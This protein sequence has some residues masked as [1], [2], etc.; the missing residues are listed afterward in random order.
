MYLSVNGDR[1][2]HTEREGFEIFDEKGADEQR[3]LL[4]GAEKCTS[5]S[6]VSPALNFSKRRQNVF[7]KI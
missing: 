6:G 4:T 7:C 3:S 5:A 1:H 2:A